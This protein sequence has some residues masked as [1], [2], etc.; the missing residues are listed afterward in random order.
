MSDLFRPAQRQEARLRMGICGP[1]GS[2]KTY[3][4]LLIASGLV[5]SHWDNVALIDTERGSGDLYAGFGPYAV[6][7]FG[8]PYSAERYVNA[9]R[10]AEA[11]GYE[12]IIMDSL[13]HAWEGEGGI[14]D[15]HGKVAQTKYRGNSYVAWREVTPKHNALVDAMLQSSAHII[16]TMRSKTEYVLTADERGKQVPKK[17]GMAP[18]QR[19]GME[20]EFTLVLDLDQDHN[21]VVSK[22]RTSLFDGKIFR[23]S[24]ETGER[25]AEWLSGKGGA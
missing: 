7:S 24:S 13:S 10:A 16:A 8:P 20:Y 3:S 1:S 23:P 21:A 4:S 25:L 6:L 11:E 19:P 9:I 5:D 22:D 2:G 14:L 12:V 18:I 17:V 15:V